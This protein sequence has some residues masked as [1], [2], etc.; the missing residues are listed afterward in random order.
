MAS[1]TYNLSLEHSSSSVT[2]QGKLE[3]TSTSNGTTANS[4]LVEVKLYARKQG[5]S[6]ATSGT[7]RG[8]IT[9]DGTQ[10]SFSQSKSVSNSWVL[11]STSS[12]TVS[13]NADGT[14][15]IT[16]AGEVGR[17]SGTTLS[18]INSTGSTSITLDTI[19]RYATLLTAPNFND[20]QN[21]TITYSNPA[22][23]EVTTLQVC[24]SFDNVQDNIPYRDISKT[25]TSYTFNLTETERTS[26]RNYFNT[27]NSGN[28]YF[29]IKCTL[30]G[31]TDY[32]II[33]RTASIINANP[34]ITSSNITCSEGNFEIIDLHLTDA[35]VGNVS[36]ISMWWT[37]PTFKKGATLDNIVFS[38]PNTSIPS[39]TTTS[40]SGSQWGLVPTPNSNFKIN[41]VVT[42]S[43]GNKGSTS[44]DVPIIPY[45]NPSI[46]ATIT[47]ENNYEDTSYLVVNATITDL[48]NKNSIQELKYRY[49]Q[50]G[51]SFNSWVNITNGST[52]TLTLDKN[53]EYE[54]EVYVADKFY[55]T[56]KTLKLNKGIFPLFIDVDLNS[57]GINT[58]PVGTQ[59]LE[60]GGDTTIGGDLEVKGS[61]V[62]GNQSIYTAS[63][64]SDTSL[65][66]TSE[67]V[68]TLAEGTYIGDKL[69]LSG[70]GIAIGSGVDYV[71]VS[72]KVNYTTLSSTA[73]MRYARIKLNGVDTIDTRN[74]VPANCTYGV[75]LSIPPQLLKV[76]QGDIITLAV[77]GTSGDVVKSKEMWTNLTI[78]VL[79]Y[80]E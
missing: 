14:K 41:A 22:G 8:S 24:I 79:S 6:T 20:T 25:G 7:F 43:R 55:G 33:Q 80:K 3:W 31:S 2:F 53:Y 1:G 72:A 32:S 9:I 4:S 30:N 46:N 35:F 56:T 16:I 52:T 69:S 36:I 27:S 39:I 49:K 10:T 28:V 61:L 70:G 5:S 37:S 58:F 51:G 65:T 13:H 26:L 64:S 18:N 66:N 11:I 57:V 77:Q 45:Y 62:L 12:K 21:P 54:I 76:Q 71:M 34:E 63:I 47:R 68:L 59:T 50:T 75:N 17:V 73:Y 19:P 42:D 15:S 38:F 74:H 44:I 29:Y 40:A 78:E 48:Q 67:K 23:N 60:T